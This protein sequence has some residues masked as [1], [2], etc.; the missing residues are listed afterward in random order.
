MTSLTYTRPWI[1]DYQKTAIFTDTRYAVIEATTKAGKTVGCIIWLT[2][3]AMKGK[4]GQN[5]WW[6][7]PIYPQAKIAYRRLKRMLPRHVY[8]ANETELTLTLANQ[9]VIWF[10][11]ADKPDSLF[12]EDV[13]AAVVDEA[14]RCKEDAW[15]AVR[16][17]LTATTGPIRIIGNVRG[18]KNWAYRMARKAESGEP[19]MSYA[20]I[21][22]RDAVG[23]GIL[24]DAEI[25]DARR[26]LPDS[27]FRELYLAEPSDDGGNPFG[28][29][30]IRQ[31]VNGLSDGSP[32]VWGWDDRTSMSRN[33]T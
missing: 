8:M 7:A 26:T 32:V 25:E 5:F 6:V 30:A 29:D 19:G 3:Q 24:E 12:G 10:K 33:R 27:V 20:K 1:T 31:C 15:H 18:R 16:T 9:A 13:Y 28:I 17:T 21:T 14:T 22:A 23:A 11:G 2:E 4:P